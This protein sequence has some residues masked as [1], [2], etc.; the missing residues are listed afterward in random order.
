MA[1][2]SAQTQRRIII[3]VIFF[4]LLLSI[5]WLIKILIGS[6]PDIAKED[7]Y[8]QGVILTALTGAIGTGLA[9]LA[10]IVK[11]MADNLREG[12]DKES[13]K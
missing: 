3:M 7:A 8:V 4:V 13:E 11:A 5:G 6:S 1:A 2:P 10:I 9:L 12:V